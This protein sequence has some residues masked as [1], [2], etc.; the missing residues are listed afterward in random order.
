MRK[1]THYL[2]TLCTIIGINACYYDG[3]LGLDESNYDVTE[4]SNFDLAGE[5]VGTENCDGEEYFYHF[6]I[7]SFADSQVVLDNVADFGYRILADVS[8]GEVSA[9]EALDLG[10]DYE[11]GEEVVISVSNFSFTKG[12]TA[13]QDSISLEYTITDRSD[14]SSF[15]CSFTGVRFNGFEG[16]Q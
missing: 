14:N 4:L 11:V 10:H 5:Y 7:A 9:N 13:V 8:D 12:E 15:T 2:L 6:F 16:E 3:D 1:L